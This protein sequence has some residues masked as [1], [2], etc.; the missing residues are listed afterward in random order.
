M[1]KKLKDFGLAIYTSLTETVLG[2]LGA[3]KALAGNPRGL[4]LFL[5]LCAFS[6][7]FATGGKLGSINFIA[8]KV[9]ELFELS[10]E[11]TGWQ[12]CTILGTLGIGYLVLDKIKK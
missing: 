5:V 10:K 2:F 4:V 6:Y 3:V 7:D 8:T 1:I 9:K 12:A 11:V